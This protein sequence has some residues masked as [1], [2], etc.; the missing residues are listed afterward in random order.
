MFIRIGFDIAYSFPQPTEMIMMLYTHPSRASFL[1]T[2][3]RLTSDPTMVI[4]DFIDVYGNKCAR[5]LSR[6]AIEFANRCHHG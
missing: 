2:P 3:E 6:R 4:E 1:M 5:F